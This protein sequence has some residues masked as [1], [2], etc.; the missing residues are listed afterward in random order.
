[1]VSRDIVRNSMLVLKVPTLAVPTLV[2][3]RLANLGANRY[4][5]VMK[6]GTLLGVDGRKYLGSIVLI[7]ID[8]IF[9]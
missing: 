8:G 3:M 2:G 1:M 7:I 6:K 9:G 4:L 5:S